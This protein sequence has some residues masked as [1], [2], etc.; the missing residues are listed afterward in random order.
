MELASL[1]CLVS[2]LS[3]AACTTVRGPHPAEV[4]GTA[5]DLVLAQQGP[6]SRVWSEPEGGSTLEYA[7]QP[8]GV[9]CWMARFDAS[10]RLVD[11]RDA[12]APGWRDRVQPGMS[13]EQVSHLL[14]HERRRMRFAPSGEEVW[15]W[16][17]APEDVS[18][19]LSFNVHFRDGLV[20]R[21]SHSY[22]TRGRM[23][24]GR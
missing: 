12:L 9:H 4:A 15:D 5:L 3:L 18:G 23:F 22:T 14:G 21:T 8:F 13:E 16:N 11:W 6:P 7:T 2:L 17:V 24:P 20:T 1:V 19:I 10:H